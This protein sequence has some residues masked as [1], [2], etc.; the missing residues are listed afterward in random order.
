MVAT[1]PRA[2]AQWR[3]KESHGLDCRFLGKKGQFNL[4]QVEGF[5]VSPSISHNREDGDV[6]QLVFQH[7][8][9]V[10]AAKLKELLAQHLQGFREAFG[11]KDSRES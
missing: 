9:H 2:W 4:S 3:T 5:G 8:E 6:L 10:Q 1:A 7:N 11:K